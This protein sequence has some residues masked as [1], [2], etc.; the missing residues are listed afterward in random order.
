MEKP[1]PS[2]KSASP[3][4][5]GEAMNYS[6]AGRLLLKDPPGIRIRIAGVDDDRQIQFPGNGNLGTE[7]LLLGIARR[8][9]VIIVKSRFADRD[10]LRMPG[11]SFSKA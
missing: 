9:I 3:S 6:A 7:N 5:D 8:M 4:L 2:A 1:I 10:D 11:S